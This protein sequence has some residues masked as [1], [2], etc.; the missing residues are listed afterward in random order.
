MTV[1][2]FDESVRR[3]RDEFARTVVAKPLEPDATPLFA[4]TIRGVKNLVCAEF[5]ITEGELLSDRR[6]RA[7]ARP[8][9]VAMWLACRV[10]NRSLPEIGTAFGNRDHTTVMHARKV[11][12]TAMAG[13]AELAAC[14]HRMA[15]QLAASTVTTSTEVLIES[16]IDEIR[17][18]LIARVRR[19]ETA[20]VLSELGAL[21]GLRPVARPERKEPEFMLVGSGRRG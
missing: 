11:I 6:G 5:G 12:D 1:S 10:T 2:H 15:K 18:K 3:T 17:S 8:R 16:V 13:D 9:M 7:L 21:A 20:A 4:G 19:G 14:V